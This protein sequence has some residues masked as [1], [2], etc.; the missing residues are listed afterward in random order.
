MEIVIT[1]KGTKADLEE[2]AVEKQK[3]KTEQFE[4]TKTIFFRI[5]K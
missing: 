1:K 5:A 4:A 2:M 3:G